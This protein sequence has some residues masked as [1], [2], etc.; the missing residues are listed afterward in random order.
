MSENTISGMRVDE[1]F[2]M[3]F[4]E[5]KQMGGRAH[6]KDIFT[7]IEPRLKLSEHER[8][9][10]KSG[11]VRWETLL[12]W[13]SVDCTKAGYLDKSGG[14]WTLTSKGEEA[15]RLPAGELIRSAQQ[16]Y[17]ASRSKRTGPGPDPAPDPGADVIEGS[18]PDKVARQTTYEQAFEA[19]RKGIEDHVNALGPYEF[20]NLVAELLHAMGYHV[21]HVAPPGADGG[22]DLVAYR[23]PLGT[24]SP[25]LR[26]QVK[27]RDQK[28]TVKELREL[29]GVLRK[30][31]DIGL[32]VSS[33][34]F[35]SDLER[36]ARSVQRHI[37]L[38]DL[39]RLIKLWIEHYSKMRETGKA[40]LPLVSVYFLAPGD[41]P[42][43]S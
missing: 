11:G 7:R 33:G 28:A 36:E 12:R 19:A 32:L 15:L 17:R 37:E 41:D 2:R 14:Y 18:D 3:V 30:E 5:L 20:Q 6:P 4:A 34:G 38:M 26:V 31:G 10:L 9:E 1:M 43:Q 39:E 35:T 13:Y 21:P 8:G 24:T 42:G 40:L 16:L 27:H 22:I 23:D 29:E 25:R